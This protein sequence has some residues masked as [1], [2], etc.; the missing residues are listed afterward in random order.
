MLAKSTLWS[1][2]QE[3]DPNYSKY[4]KKRETGYPPFEMQD[5]GPKQILY[6]LMD[7]DPKG[8]PEGTDILQDPWITS[9]YMCTQTQKAEANNNELHEEVATN[10]DNHTRAR[11]DSCPHIHLTIPTAHH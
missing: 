8:R 4:L 7:P 1:S 3:S 6:K 5:L 2:A 11:S 10:D 9:V